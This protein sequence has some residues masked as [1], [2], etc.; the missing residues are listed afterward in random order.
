M[1]HINSPIPFSDYDSFVN[2]SLNDILPQILKTDINTITVFGQKIPNM[3]KYNLVIDLLSSSKTLTEEL[4]NNFLPFIYNQKNFSKNPKFWSL[5]QLIFKNGLTLAIPLSTLADEDF[6]FKSQY[7]F[8][9]YPTN[10]SFKFLYN[11]REL[12]MNHLI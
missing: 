5:V 2:E 4:L 7:Y 8:L 12:S 3:F 11:L 1:A 9:F 6:L 10:Y